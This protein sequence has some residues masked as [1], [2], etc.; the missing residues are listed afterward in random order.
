MPV[1]TGRGPRNRRVAHQPLGFDSLTLC[2]HSTSPIPLDFATPRVIL[3]VFRG[4]RSLSIQAPADNRGFRI[5][6]GPGRAR[7]PMCPKAFPEKLSSRAKRLNARSKFNH[8]VEGPRCP[9]E[10]QRRS[11]PRNLSHFKNLDCAALGV[12]LKVRSPHV[13]FFRPPRTMLCRAA[14]GH[15]KI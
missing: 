9:P 12:I 2:G 10:P 3:E 1:G 7:L 5:S 15:A 6:G 4:P 11:A 8:T 13:L 14:T